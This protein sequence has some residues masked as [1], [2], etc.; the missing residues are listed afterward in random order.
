MGGSLSK[1]AFIATYGTP[2]SSTPS[3]YLDLVWRR[4]RQLPHQQESTS[5]DHSLDELLL[6]DNKQ[7]QHEQSIDTP[8]SFSET[9]VWLPLFE[10][11]L[12][13]GSVN[14]LELV[15]KLVSQV[16]EGFEGRVGHSGELPLLR[17]ETC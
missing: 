6:L 13:F 16:Q 11:G 2:S 5:P 10:K 17:L 9:N 4:V 1:V 14:S 15:T 8:E 7:R 12:S 3:G